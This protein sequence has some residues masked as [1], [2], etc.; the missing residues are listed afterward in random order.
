MPKKIFSTV[1]KI[2]KEPKL[3]LQFLNDM[4][5]ELVD[6]TDM[7]VSILVFVSII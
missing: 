7:V 4:R 3:Y 1:V 2:K 6:M 5:N